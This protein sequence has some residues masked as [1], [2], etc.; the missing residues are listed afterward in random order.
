MELANGTVVSV[1]YKNDDNGF[2]VV[3]VSFD[4]APQPVTC[5]GKMPL[6]EKGVSISVKGHWETHPK[7]GR[8]FLVE[9]YTRVRPTSIEGITKLL[10][11]GVVAN[12]GPKRARQIVERF[13]LETLDVLDNHPERLTE[14]PG[15]GAKTLVKIT[16]KWSRD[17]EFR[18]LLL[19]L[20]EYD[21]SLSMALKIHRAY[22]SKALETINQNP[23]LLCEDIWGIGF[24]KADQIAVKLGI[25]RD[26]YKRIQA[27]IVFV[28]N[29]S[30][31]EGHSCLPN[32]MVLNNVAELLNV[33]PEKVLFSLDHLISA[34]ILKRDDEFIYLP[35]LL[36]A[37]NTIAAFVRKRIRPVPENDASRIETWLAEYEKKTGWVA[38][39]VQ[40]MAVITAIRQPC[41][42]LTGGPGT[43]KTTVLK[44]LVAYLIAHQQ[45]VL[46][47]A[48]T[49]RAAQ[50]MTDVTGIIAQTIHRLL[51][52]RPNRSEGGY[53]FSRNE[54][55]PLEA[56]VIIIDEASMIDVHLMAK[57]CEAIA[58]TTRLLLVGDNN[59]LPSVGPGNVLG[60]LIDSGTISHVTLK[61][62]FRQARDSRIITAAHEINS[63]IT[64]VFSN[65]HDENCFFLEEADPQKALDLLLEVVTQRLP[66]KYGLDPVKEIQVLS[67]MHRGVLGTEHINAELQKM[68]RNSTAKV[69]TG[70]HSFYRG[71]K[72][73]QIKNNYDKNIFNGDIGLV[74]D[75]IDD[76]TGLLVKFPTDTVAYL[77]DELDELVPAYCISIHKSQGSEFNTVVIPLSTQHFIMLQKNL[78]YTALTRAK[79]MCIFIGTR[80][81][82]LLAV[83]SDK[84]TIRYSRLCHRL[85]SVGSESPA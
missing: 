67:P 69:E 47:A 9:S 78:V 10:A 54:N 38:D 83:R 41:M 2:A 7:F 33:E 5:T 74:A 27:G 13:G 79:R 4:D 43:G 31:Q 55:N 26:S 59:Q 58:G 18:Q 46:L 81:A 75:F 6:I 73:M 62:V 19:Y 32:T 42:L 56:D 63:T 77:A 66:S 65:S 25:T 61:N 20:Q 21:V 72:V 84:T 34:G 36:S 64:P 85:S 40:R 51:E 80:R 30:A 23:Y 24:I 45:K 8:Q 68:L 70:R 3:K 76:E 11:S 35:Y 37:E 57:L 17:R 29:E 50:R 60:D 52:Y 71:D 1:T 39:P 49:G 28:M 16:E 82:L 48:P 12:V 22:G 14:I 15:I 44:V 53:S